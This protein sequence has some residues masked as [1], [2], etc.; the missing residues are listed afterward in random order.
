MAAKTKRNQ[1]KQQQRALRKRTQRKQKMARRQSQEPQRETPARILRRAREMPI[2]GAW[3][4][5]GWQ[6]RGA[7]VVVLARTN[8]SDNIVFGEYVVDYLCT[9]VKD[10]AFAT[11]VSPEVF[12]NEVIP[13]L[14]G[15]IPP[16]TAA[17]EL[18]HEIV[19]GAVEYAE[20]LG[21]RPPSAFRQ[22]QRILE[23]PDALPRPDVVVFGYQGR[24]AYVP[25]PQDNQAAIIARLIDSVGL[26]NFYYIPQG[27]IPD[28]VM[29]LL[30]I[31]QGEGDEAGAP[32]WTPEGQQTPGSADSGSGLWTPE[33]QAA[34][35]QPADAP[36][37]WTPGRA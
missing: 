2:E 23:A 19:W 34:Q 28:D 33:Q 3:V 30:Q 15:G 7:A 31:E 16:I 20:T 26:G 6:E 21:L 14:Y 22:S 13:R 17:V 12:D 4:Q 24:P 10:T 35:E 8:S 29:E 36:G 32:L 9:G 11:N 37:L 27:D 5:E 18:V 1:H 25:A